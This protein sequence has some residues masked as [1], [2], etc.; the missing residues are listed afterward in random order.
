M[1]YITLERKI[2][3]DGR[4][5]RALHKQ[6]YR[7]SDTQ[8]QWTDENYGEHLDDHIEKLVDIRNRKGKCELQEVQQEE[9]WI[10]RLPPLNMNQQSVI[11]CQPVVLSADEPKETVTLQ[12]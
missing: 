10:G 3:E 7:W 12:Y 9:G 11:A 1:K 2:K 8:H 4:K 6:I 5:L